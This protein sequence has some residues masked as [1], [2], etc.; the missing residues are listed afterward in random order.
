M[1]C[2]KNELGPIPLVAMG[3]TSGQVALSF[4]KE[5]LIASPCKQLQMLGQLSENGETVIHTMG[6]TILFG[7]NQ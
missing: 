5:D 2:W 4:V 1:K 6:G 7:I 3:T